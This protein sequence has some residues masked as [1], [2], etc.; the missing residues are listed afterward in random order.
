MLNTVLNYA[1]PSNVPILALM[2]T[3]KD[4]VLPFSQFGLGD[5]VITLADVEDAQRK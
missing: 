5:F 1:T 4:F 2:T 3:E